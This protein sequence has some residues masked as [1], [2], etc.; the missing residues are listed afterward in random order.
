MMKTLQATLLA[1]ASLIAFNAQADLALAQASG[2]LACHQ[3]AVKLV[4]PSYNEIAAKYKDQ[5]GAHEMLVQSVINGGVG[6]WG[7]IP[8]PPK[9]GRADVSDEDIGKLVTWILSH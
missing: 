3:E 9:G 2:C 4:G 8:M 7:Q 6:K 5:E 1:G